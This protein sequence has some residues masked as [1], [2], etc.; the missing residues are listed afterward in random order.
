VLR[1][2]IEIEDTRSQITFAETETAH[3]RGERP[4]PPMDDR[5]PIDWAFFW[6][7]VRTVLVE[8]GCDPLRAAIGQAAFEETYTLCE[9]GHAFELI[10]QMQPYESRDDPK[11]FLIAERTALRTTFDR[12]RGGRACYYAAEVLR[13][14]GAAI[15]SLPYLAES[16]ENVSIHIMEADPI[17]SQNAWAG[18]PLALLRAGYS[19]R[20]A[21]FVSSNRLG[22]RGSSTAVLLLTA[23]H[24]FIELRA[25]RSRRGKLQR[26]DAW[27]PV[28][29]DEA[30]EGLG[31]VADAAL[32]VARERGW[33]T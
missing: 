28:S 30:Q 5:W 15:E 6:E 16:V 7:Q 3:L 12:T 2:Y 13:S 1:G 4:P 9:D 18:L 14:R 27:R 19:D 24:G 33:S 29:I 11:L 22:P 32:L 25:A 26:F 21:L 8:E 23:E 31:S 10:P 20:T 17:S